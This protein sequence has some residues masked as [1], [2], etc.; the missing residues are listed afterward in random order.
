MLGVGARRPLGKRRLA[1]VDAFGDGVVDDCVN[2]ASLSG[3][4]LQ[5]PAREGFRLSV[6][7]AQRP[8]PACLGAAYPWNG[9]GAVC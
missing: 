4:L 6:D 1:L 7:R 8:P 3:F 9:S 2:A 5:V